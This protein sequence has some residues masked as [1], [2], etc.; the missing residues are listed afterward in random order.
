MTLKERIKAEC[1]KKGISVSKL[2]KDLGFANAYINQLNPET[3]Q[4][5][6]L[7]K[8]ADYLNVDVNYLLTGEES[9][10]YYLNDETA[11]AAQEIF[12]NPELRLLFDEARNADPE[13]LK[14]VHQMLLALKRKE[15]GEV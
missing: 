9:A 12:D 15:N 11:K 1:K 10:G 2:E 14:T 8:I 4:H 7:I 6:R 5:S 3:I 13:D